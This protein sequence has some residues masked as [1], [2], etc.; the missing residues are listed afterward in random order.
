MS[1]D[2]SLLKRAHEQCECCSA[3]EKLAAYEVPASATSGLEANYFFV[4]NVFQKQMQRREI[5]T[6]GAV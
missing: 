4:K 2:K 5:K 6:I 1:I 3:T